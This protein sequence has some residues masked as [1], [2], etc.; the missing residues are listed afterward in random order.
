[1]PNVVKIDPYNC[2][3]YRFKVCAYFLRH[4]VVKPTRFSVNILTDGEAANLLRTCCGETGVIDFGHKRHV[5]PTV[6]L[7]VVSYF[8]L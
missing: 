7:A 1:L 2:E 6:S 3:V 5:Q 4:S 8:N